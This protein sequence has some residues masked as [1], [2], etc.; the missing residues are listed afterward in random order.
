[1]SRSSRGLGHR[2]FT[3][4]TGVRLPYGIPHKRNLALCQVFLCHYE[5]VGELVRQA[6]GMVRMQSLQ[7][8]NSAPQ[9]AYEL[10]PWL[11]LFLTN[12]RIPHIHVSQIAEVPKTHG[13]SFRPPQCTSNFTQQKALDPAVKPRDDNPLIL[14]TKLPFPTTPWLCYY[15]CRQIRQ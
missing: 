11:D 5:S 14:N 7:E 8:Q 6:P 10:W 13:C 4:V 15:P 3:A 9:G 1:M 12:L 2:P